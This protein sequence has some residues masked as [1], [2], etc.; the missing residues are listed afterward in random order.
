VTGGR[1]EQDRTCRA[2]G[3]S[4]FVSGLLLAL[5][6]L[7]GADLL[8]LVAMGDHVRATGTVPDGVPFAAA[9]SEGWP[10]ALLLSELVLSFVHEAGLAGLLV[11]HYLLVLT[12]LGLVAVGA[13]LRGG[14]DLTTALV[15]GALLLGG[16]ATFGVVRLQS[17]SLVPFAIV[18]ILVRA[19]HARPSRAMWW[20]PALVA[21]WGNLHGS[22]LLGVCVIGAYLLFSRLRH[23]LVETLLIG[24]STLGALLLNPAG[25]RTPHYYLGV[26]RNQAAAQKEGLWAAPSLTNPFDVLM[27]VA[28]VVLGGCAL[29]HKLAPWEYVALAGLAV[30][31]AG[32]ARNGVW[33]LL[34]LAAPAAYGLVRARALGRPPPGW[35]GLRPLIVLAVGLGICGGVLVQRS[36][37]RSETDTALAAEV[38]ESAPGL[39]VLAPE[40]VVESLAVHGVRVWLA[41]PLDAFGQEDQS[42]YLDFMSGRP[43]MARA[44]AGSDAVLVEAGTPAAAQMA[45]TPGF[46]LTELSSEWLLYLRS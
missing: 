19:Q 38:R 1:D 46:D 42:A 26:L 8:W 41:N 16:I 2:V 39:V 28:A 18:L 13:R 17:F 44:V 9:S 12:A 5:L 36:Q 6:I 10:P 30:A 37:A 40:P 29:R 7:V 20:A 4:L 11:W 34:F 27:I 23:R 25:W 22:V 35:P 32:A 45:G 21:I 14:T 3:A 15:L 43:G 24:I 31:T 33:L